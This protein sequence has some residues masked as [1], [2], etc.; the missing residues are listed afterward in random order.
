MYYDLKFR[1]IPYVE[2]KFSVI[3]FDHQHQLMPKGSVDGVLTRYNLLGPVRLPLRLGGEIVQFNWYL[4]FLDS[5]QARSK[6][7]ETLQEGRIDYDFFTKFSEAFTV[8]SILSLG[9]QPFNDDPD[10][11]PVVRIHSCCAT[12][13]IFGSVRCDCGPQLHAALEK[14][15]A[16]GYG[17]VVYLNGQEGRGIGLFAKALT[18]L[19]QE[20]GHDTYEANALL[21]LPEDARTFDD[22]GHMLKYLYR[23]KALRLMTNSP[24][25]IS[26][27]QR[28]GVAVV[29]RVELMT[30][31]LPQNEAYLRAK[32]A[33]GRMISLEPDQ[34]TA[35]TPATDS[36]GTDSQTDI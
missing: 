18:Y 15:V 14:I 16:G 17:A 33:H 2:S 24:Y 35:P 11:I 23:G 32:A 20:C 21:K 6:I 34:A 12:G 27:L 19:L 3:E 9:E 30:G 36:Q 29:E 8:S 7:M 5:E 22:A 31:M 4:Y 1:H 28:V 10:A 25:K 26:A 13:D